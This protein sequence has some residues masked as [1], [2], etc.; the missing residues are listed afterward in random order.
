MS[1]NI[2]WWLQVDMALDVGIGMV[3]LD[4]WIEMPHDLGIELDPDLGIADGSTFQD[5][6]CKPVLGTY[7]YGIASSYRQTSS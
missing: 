2:L 4:L 3:A 7:R 1:V 5:W 6:G